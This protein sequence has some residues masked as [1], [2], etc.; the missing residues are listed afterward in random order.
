M[1]RAG[2]GVIIHVYEMDGTRAH[3]STYYRGGGYLPSIIIL[4]MTNQIL[5]LC[6]CDHDPALSVKEFRQT[7]VSG[8]AHIKP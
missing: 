7:V 3:T 8:D 2:N 1:S 4:V 5:Q 6:L